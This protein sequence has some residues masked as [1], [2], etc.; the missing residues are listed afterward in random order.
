MIKAL[1]TVKDLAEYLGTPVSWVYDN[2]HEIPHVRV[3]REYRF[4]QQE[5]DLWL[6][7]SRGGCPLKLLAA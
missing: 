7:A 6:E 1:W 4:R 3:G 5:V 2:A